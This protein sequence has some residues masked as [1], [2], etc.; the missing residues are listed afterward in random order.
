MVYIDSEKNLPLKELR[1]CLTWIIVNGCGEQMA[2]FW[3][4]YRHACVVT[5]SILLESVKPLQDCRLR[6]WKLKRPETSLRAS[7]ENSTVAPAEYADNV[8]TSRFIYRNMLT[9]NLPSYTSLGKRSRCIIHNKI[10]DKRFRDFQ[11]I[12]TGFR[13]CPI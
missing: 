13:S 11:P 12:S 9:P 4:H 7:S 3:I 1:S 5:P 8:Y 6:F 2:F 10:I